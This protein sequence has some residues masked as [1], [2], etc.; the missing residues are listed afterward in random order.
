MSEEESEVKQISCKTLKKAI[1]NKDIESCVVNLRGHFKCGSGKD[2]N[3]SE[4][5]A[6]I[7]LLVKEEYLEEAIEVTKQ[8]LVREAYPL[9]RIFRFL[10]NRLAS[11]GKVEAMNDIGSYLKPKIKKEVVRW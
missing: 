8:M 11:T 2:L 10:L 4:S 5:S 6:L 3:I 9:P 1:A 7:E